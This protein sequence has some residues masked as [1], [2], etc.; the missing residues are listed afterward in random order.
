[1]PF[2]GVV[3]LMNYRRAPVCLGSIQFLAVNALCYLRVTVGVVQDVVAW[4]SSLANAVWC[5]GVV[6]MMGVLVVSTFRATEN[7]SLCMVG[8]P[9]V[10]SLGV[11]R[12]GVLTLVVHIE[13]GNE[14][15]CRAVALGVEELHVRSMCALV[16]LLNPLGSRVVAKV[17][18]WP[19]GSTPVYPLVGACTLGVIV[20][21]K[22]SPVQSCI[23]TRPVVCKCSGP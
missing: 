12:M 17:V 8:P 19:V 1:M 4:V 7:C 21:W 22:N 16:G 15:L 23:R 3:M 18:C 20:W 13:M 14:V 6:K 5:L 11:G 10:M 9:A 2:L